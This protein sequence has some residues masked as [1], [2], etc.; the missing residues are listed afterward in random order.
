MDNKTWLT[1]N[2]NKVFVF[3]A[4]DDLWKYFKFG[5]FYYFAAFRPPNTTYWNISLL[6]ALSAFGLSIVTKAPELKSVTLMNGD[7]GGGFLKALKS[8]CNILASYSRLQKR[9]VSHDGYLVTKKSVNSLLATFTLKIAERSTN[10]IW[11]TKSKQTCRLR[12]L[13]KLEPDGVCKQNNR[14]SLTLQLSH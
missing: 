11:W 13:K 5:C 9:R 10:L 3:Y 12:F 7:S 4:N 14:F 6:I 2:E 8:L 1:R